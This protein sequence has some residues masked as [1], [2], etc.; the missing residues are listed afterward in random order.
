MRA[1]E[2]SRDGR[3]RSSGWPGGRSTRPRRAGE[4][5]VPPGRHPRPRRRRGAGRRRRRRRAP[6]VHHL[7]RPRGDARDQPRGLAQRVRGRGRRAA[8]KRLVYTSSVAAYGFHARQ[9]AAAHRGRPAARHASAHYYSA[10]KAE[11]EETLLDERVAGARP[12]PTCFRPCI[13]AGPDALMLVD[14]PTC[15]SPAAPA[16]CRRSLARPRP[17]IPDPGRAASSSCTP[18][19]SRARSRRRRS[20]AAS[21]A[22]TTSP[23]RAR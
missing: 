8:R 16:R 4:D 23:A 5:R 15:A 13:V 11:L 2:R 12:R 14:A 17:V 3:A 22:S 21:P 9:P 19:T 1:L 7:R 18:T 10:Q 20:A 6:R